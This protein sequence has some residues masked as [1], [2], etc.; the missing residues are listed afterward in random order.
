MASILLSN[1]IRN[2]IMEPIKQIRIIIILLRKVIMENNYSFNAQA[3]SKYEGLT[4]N[5]RELMAKKRRITKFQ[6]F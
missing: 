4:Q 2:T 3:V 5:Y 1:Y 6:V